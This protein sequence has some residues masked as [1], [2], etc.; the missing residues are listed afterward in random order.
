V[1]KTTDEV[2]D[3]YL[4]GYGKKD[5]SQ[6]MKSIAIYQIGLVYMSRLNDN[7]DDEKAKMY[8]QRHLIEFPYSIL[9]ERIEERL[10]TI[11]DR[12]SLTSH[13]SQ[14]QIIN[15]ADRDSVTAQ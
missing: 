14:Q 6:D 2:I 8:F 4:I 12:K 11:N 10:K 5:Y 1:N 13:P 7:R 15:Q 3:T 9:H